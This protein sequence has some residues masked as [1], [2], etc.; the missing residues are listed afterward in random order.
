MFH[1]SEVFPI[2]GNQEAKYLEEELKLNHELEFEFNSN[3]GFNCLVQPTGYWMVS[4]FIPN[5]D[6]DQASA[7]LHVLRRTVPRRWT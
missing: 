3:K 6:F 2:K 7:G 1:L 5:L 4:N